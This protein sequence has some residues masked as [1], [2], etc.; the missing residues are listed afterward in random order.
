MEMLRDSHTDY[1]ESKL[2]IIARTLLKMFNNGKASD[3]LEPYN[4]T[5]VNKSIIILKYDGKIEIIINFKRKTV[6]YSSPDYL[7]SGAI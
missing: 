4:K 7:Y 1:N 3:N 5:E 2:E 6:F